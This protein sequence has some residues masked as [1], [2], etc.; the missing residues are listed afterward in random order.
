MRSRADAPATWRRAV[1]HALHAAG[2]ILLLILLWRTLRPAAVPA[3]DSGRVTSL[4]RLIPLLPALTE[5]PA[6]RSI[7]TSIGATPSP[8]ALDWLRALR[9]AG[10]DVRWSSAA[11]APLA[12]SVTPIAD[13]AGGYTIAAAAPAGARV[14]IADSAGV[15]DTVTARGGGIRVNVPWA[16]RSVS[17]AVDGTNASW[18][19]RPASP[20]RAVLVEGSARWETKFAVAAL[21]E[22]GWKV[23]ALSHVAPGVTIRTGAP[24]TPDTA[25]YAAVVIVDTAA[26]LAIRGLDGYV[27]AGGGLVTLHDAAAVGPWSAPGVQL[28]RGPD[29]AVTASRVGAGRVV[30]VGYPDLW[31]RRMRGSDGS[32]ATSGA[33]AGARGGAA[34]PVAV[35]RAWLAGIV[36][37]VVPVSTVSDPAAAA[38]WERAA[39][40]AATVDRL[41]PATQES[42]AGG[43]ESR[44]PAS[45]LPTWL[46]FT[47]ACAAFTTEWASRRLRGAR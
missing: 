1:E 42:D 8:V 13:P 22:R 23:D 17:V 3:A 44:P 16:Y 6:V 2:V 30:R 14:T 36:A 21:Q 45:R 34:D 9:R 43:R 24:A 35:E 25:S 38:A 5:S 32:G 10:V 33:I 12:L 18:P 28:E 47:A 15:L 20:L 41:G 31:R 37:A 46:L 7:H 19:V 11:L 4:G 27:R 26:T 39:P 29:G 40:V